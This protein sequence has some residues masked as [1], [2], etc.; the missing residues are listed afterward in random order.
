VEENLNKLIDTLGHYVGKDKLLLP[1]TLYLG[2]APSLQV[3]TRWKEGTNSSAFPI[4][5]HDELF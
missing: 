1:S 5:Q 2:F 3:T 4:I